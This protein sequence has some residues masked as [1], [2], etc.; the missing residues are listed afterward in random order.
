MDHTKKTEMLLNDDIRE[1]CRDFYQRASD[2]G[3]ALYSYNY[4]TK[5]PTEIPVIDCGISIFIIL[6]GNQRK[7]SVYRDFSYR[8]MEIC[9]EWSQDRVS[10]G[11]GYFE[12]NLPE[13]E[14][15]EFQLELE[16]V[17]SNP[18]NYLIERD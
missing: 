1:I 13:E 9:Y 18:Q 2:N 17:F 5:E 8:S 12:V 16:K 6:K 11:W 14:I 4:E 3:T 7:Y 15:R 10:G